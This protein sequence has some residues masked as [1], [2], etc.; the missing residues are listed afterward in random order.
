MNQ[1]D[2][3]V[4]GNVGVLCL[5]LFLAAIGRVHHHAMMRNGLYAAA[6]WIGGVFTMR[7]LNTLGV[8]TPAEARLFNGWFAWVVLS[9]LVASWITTWWVERRR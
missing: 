8:A 9:V 4:V 2:Q 7:M 3:Q 6:T 1:H 5:A